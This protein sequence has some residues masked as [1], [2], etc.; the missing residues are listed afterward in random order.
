MPFKKLRESAL[1]SILDVDPHLPLQQPLSLTD[2]DAID[3]A[4][5]V[6]RGVLGASPSL[7]QRVRALVVLGDLLSVHDPAGS[8]N[9]FSE[10]LTHAA[11]VENAEV[12]L[13]AELRR[14]HEMLA[15]HGR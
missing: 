10:A 15:L 1:A 13:D 2:R 7:T 4:A 6:L 5:I 14:A 11:R 12:L 8:H 9:A 3:R